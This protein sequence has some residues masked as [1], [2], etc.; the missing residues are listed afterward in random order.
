MSRYLI[1]LLVT[2]PYW[3]RKK[4]TNIPMALDKPAPR[5]GADISQRG[6]FRRKQLHP[7]HQQESRSATSALC[8]LRIGEDLDGPSISNSPISRR[9][10]YK[11]SIQMGQDPNPL[12]TPF[13][14]FIGGSR[15]SR[16]ARGPNSTYLGT[17]GTLIQV[18]AVVSTS[19]PSV[20]SIGQQKMCFERNKCVVVEYNGR[21]YSLR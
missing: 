10:F 5:I 17:L 1:R 14:Q 15:M 13:V 16:V 8:E 11:N 4:A 2:P 3:S 21:V 19:T 9:I 6:P 20:R 18:C 7:D 12:A